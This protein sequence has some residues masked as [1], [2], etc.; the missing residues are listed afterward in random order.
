M[1]NAQALKK[2]SHILHVFS[3]RYL[4]HRKGLRSW[5]DFKSIPV[6][7][8]ED[9]KGS[10]NEGLRDAAFNITATS[11][12]TSSRMIIAHSRKAY[13]VHLRRL[14]KLYR[15]FGVKEGMLCLNLCSYEL[16]SGGR[17]ME[18]AFKAAGCGVIPLGPISTPD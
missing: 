15:L 11:G 2:V 9:L 14:V 16:N 10:V 3:K 7:G 12:S 17:M 1:F 6:S 5:E 4:H 13:E 18:A 8:R